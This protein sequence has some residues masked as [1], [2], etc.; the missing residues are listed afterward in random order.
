MGLLH[1]TVFN[2]SRPNDPRP[3]PRDPTG[4]CNTT[5]PPHKRRAPLAKDLVE[6]QDIVKATVGS[7]QSPCFTVNNAFMADSGTLVLTWTDP[8]GEISLLRKQLSMSFPGKPTPQSNIIHSSVIR[9]LSPEAI[10]SS[11]IRKIANICEEWSALWKGTVYHPHKAWYVYEETFGIV[12]GP[13][14][15]MPFNS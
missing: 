15:S 8:C 6:E 11:V 13:R 10:D 12:I 14:V 1:I 4:G 9:V 7:I 2:V 5:H 3:N